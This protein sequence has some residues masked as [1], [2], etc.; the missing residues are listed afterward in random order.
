MKNVL[1]GHQHTHDNTGCVDAMIRN[2]ISM[3]VTINTPETWC[4]LWIS[5]LDCPWQHGIQA[6]A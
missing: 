2:K 1:D 4:Q 3:T 5:S 6:S